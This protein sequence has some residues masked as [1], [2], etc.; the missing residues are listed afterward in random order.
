MTGIVLFDAVDIAQIP[1]GPQAVAGYVDGRWP[2]A[3]ALA[4]RFPHARLLTIAVSAADDAEALDVETGDA[5]PPEAAGWHQRQQARGVARPCLYASVDLMQSAVLPAM[6]TAGIDR[7]AVRVW[8]A[9]YA[10]KHV[11]GPSSCGEMAVDAD[12]TQ[13]CDN[14]YGRPL[15]QSLLAAD[16][17]G[18]PP[19]APAK[20]AV[21][22][23][24]TQGQDSLAT[25]A[26]AH[27]TAAATIIRLTAQHGPGGE[28]SAPVAS[29]LNTLFDGV[30]SVTDPVPPDLTLFLPA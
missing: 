13:W 1:A 22:S 15:D 8:T 6:K 29:W 12:G 26:K 5:S 11:C 20:P 3:Q 25:L 18:D 4:A 30:S 19:G 27:G 17:F 14:A 24:V 28:F 10:G 9:H 2:T 16:F 21:R 7:S 23:W